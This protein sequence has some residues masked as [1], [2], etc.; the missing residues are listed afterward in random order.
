MCDYS[1][2]NVKS[3]PAK[4]GE[5]LRTQHFNTHNWICCA[6]R[7]QDGGL[8]SSGNRACLCNPSTC[9]MLRLE[10]AYRQ[11]HDGHLSANRQGQAAKAS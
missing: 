8:R 1:L 2:Q 10:S 4:V 11:L 7:Y 5:K 3:R 9:R 6:R